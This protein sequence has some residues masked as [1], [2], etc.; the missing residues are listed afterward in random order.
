MSVCTVFVWKD[1]P[2]QITSNG[3]TAT[4]FRFLGYREHS[5]PQY[6]THVRHLTGTH[7]NDAMQPSFSGLLCHPVAN[8]S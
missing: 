5:C 7:V 6:A 8:V 2:I 1:W 3:S 4:P